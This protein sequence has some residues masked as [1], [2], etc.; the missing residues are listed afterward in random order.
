MVKYSVDANIRKNMVVQEH[1]DAMIN[2]MLVLFEESYGFKL[3][4]NER[5]FFILRA[6]G[7]LTYWV[8][9]VYDEAYSSVKNLESALD[10]SQGMVKRLREESE[11]NLQTITE[12]KNST[13][14]PE[15]DTFKVEL[16]PKARKIAEE[17]EK[18][19]LFPDVP[20]LTYRFVDKNYTK[21]PKKP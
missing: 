7:V 6:K 12:L 19:S 9:M 3:S 10:T 21:P 18:K 1:F 17:K 4:N 13:I 14:P 15:N 2:D 5:E 20:D 11:R 8:G 16:T